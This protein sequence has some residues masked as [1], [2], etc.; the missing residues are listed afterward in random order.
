MDLYGHVQYIQHQTSIN[1]NFITLVAKLK[2]KI[3]KIYCFKFS[4]AFL[5]P[6]HKPVQFIY[7]FSSCEELFNSNANSWL[8]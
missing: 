1:D 6:F 5:S 8:K 3:L 2:P 4:T 7:I